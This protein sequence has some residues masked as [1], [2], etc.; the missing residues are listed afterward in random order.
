[1]AFKLKDL[2]IDV[3]PAGRP[4]FGTACA[5]HT[6]APCI[7]NSHLCVNP[8]FCAYPSAVQCTLHSLTV[9]PNL[10]GIYCPYGSIV[11]T[12]TILTTGCGG[13][14]DPTYVLGGQQVDLAT[15][16]EQ[17]R[18]ALTQVEEQERAAEAAARPQT[19]EQAADLEAKL[20]GALEEV[21]SMKKTL[22]SGGTK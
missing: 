19:Q 2:M 17:L 4:Q 21:R 13:S 5:T 7:N 20:E 1:M 15:L 3:L 10:S 12:T 6:I 8:S 14:I 18:A 9:C 11:V 22:P 16:K